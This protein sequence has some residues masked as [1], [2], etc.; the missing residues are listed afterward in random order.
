MRE[1]ASRMF[2]GR[3][4]EMDGPAA[5]NDLSPQV[6]LHMGMFRRVLSRADLVTG[7]LEGVGLRLIES[8]RYRGAESV[9]HL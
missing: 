8:M 6:N 4:F 3:L 9:R 2:R 5:V 1:E 7:P